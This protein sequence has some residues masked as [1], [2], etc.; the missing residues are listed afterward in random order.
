MLGDLEKKRILVNIQTYGDFDM[1]STDVIMIAPAGWVLG[2]VAKV[3]NTL[4]KR[5][6]KTN[7]TVDVIKEL[8]LLG[9]TVLTTV[10]LTIGGDL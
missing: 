5:N 8:K 10:D 2:G 3:A 4:E 9:F 1:P 6:S 7:D